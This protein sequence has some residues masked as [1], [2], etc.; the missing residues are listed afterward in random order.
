VHGD[1]RLAVVSRRSGTGN[2]SGHQQAQSG[3]PEQDKENGRL[4]EAAPA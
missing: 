2:V 4:D 3:N 1:D